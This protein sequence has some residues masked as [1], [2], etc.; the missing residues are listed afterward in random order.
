MNYVNENHNSSNLTAT[1][2]FT[3]QQLGASR[4]RYN[5]LY[6]FDINLNEFSTQYIW[7]CRDSRNV[8]YIILLNYFLS[9]SNA[10]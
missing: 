7:L 9:I 10:I 3:S 1:L 5:N 4:N 8:N 6:K 2:L